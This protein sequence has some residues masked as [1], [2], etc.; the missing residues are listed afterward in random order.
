MGWPTF[1]G[2][3]FYTF[4]SGQ[5]S[6]AGLIESDGTAAGT[7]KVQTD[8]NRFQQMLEVDGQ[9]FVTAKQG[10]SNRTHDIWRKT[11]DTNE[12]KR[13][14][15]TSAATQLT[16]LGNRLSFVRRGELWMVTG[17]TADQVTDLAVP[18]RW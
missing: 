6:F 15:R 18:R 8:L 1:V 17:D 11:A 3:K 10:S 16:S 14:S 2:D 9:L 13:L 5:N 7:F 4:E 12:F